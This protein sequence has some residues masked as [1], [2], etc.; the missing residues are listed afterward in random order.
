T[1]GYI[2]RKISRLELQRTIK[3]LR[4]TLNNLELKND[5]LKQEI[6]DLDAEHNSVMNELQRHDMKAKKNW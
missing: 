6:N 4:T 1:G 2:D 5:A 3:Q